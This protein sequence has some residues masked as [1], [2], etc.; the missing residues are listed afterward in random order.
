MRVMKKI[1]MVLSLGLI[2]VTASASVSN[3]ENGKEY[4]LLERPQPTDAG[5]KIEVIEFFAY[6]CPHCYV[7]DPILSDWVKKQGDNI[8]F[9]RIHVSDS[10]VVPHQKLFYSLEAMGKLEELHTKIFNA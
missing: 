1:L 4:T 9:K 6:Y 10:R 5:K 2:A 7:F 3:P 8:A